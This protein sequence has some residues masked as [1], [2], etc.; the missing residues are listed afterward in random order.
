[1]PVGEISKADAEERLKAANESD[2]DA[3]RR[4]AEA[5]VAAASS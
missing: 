1:M 4:I 2:D 5:M 3:E